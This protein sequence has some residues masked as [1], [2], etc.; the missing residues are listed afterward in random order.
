[1]IW[2]IIPLVLLLFGALAWLLLYGGFAW[3]LSGCGGKF[4]QHLRR[5]DW[6]SWRMAVEDK[7]R[8]LAELKAAEPPRPDVP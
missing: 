2:I 4:G 3:I 7:E 5:S 1:M 8:E 6:N